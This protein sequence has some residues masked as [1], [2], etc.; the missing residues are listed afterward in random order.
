MAKLAAVAV[1][2]AVVATLPRRDICTA[3]GC[4]SD[5]SMMAR[6]SKRMGSMSTRFR[7]TVTKNKTDK[8]VGE[9]S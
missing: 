6:A 4:N 7:K 5:G 2:K 8:D 9:D 3:V 1:A